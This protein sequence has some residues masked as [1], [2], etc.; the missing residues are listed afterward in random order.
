MYTCTIGSWETRPR[1]LSISRSVRSPSLLE[2]AGRGAPRRRLSSSCPV[3]A[4]LPVT[5]SPRPQRAA[6]PRWAQLFPT[7]RSP[8]RLSL[9]THTL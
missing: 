7:S 5:P 6:L 2:P 1:L 3:A 4:C 9:L 8:P